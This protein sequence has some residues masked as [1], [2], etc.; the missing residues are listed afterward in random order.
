EAISPA[1]QDVWR[2]GPFERL[3]LQPLSA[4][5][6]AALLCAALGG[7]VE[8]VTAR[9]LWMLTRG[10]ALYLHHIVEQEVSDGRLVEGHGYGRWSGEPVVAPALIELIESRIGA[11]PPAIGAVIDALAVG[12]PIELGPLAR[13]TDPAAVEGADVRGLITL[14]QVDG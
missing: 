13:I 1:V 10:N 6:S 3:Y 11:L 2:S 7:P 4:D 12:E 8:P 5:E 14:E 9:R